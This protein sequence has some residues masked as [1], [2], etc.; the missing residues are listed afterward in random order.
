MKDYY[1]MYIPQ[2]VL[3]LLYSYGNLATLS[4]AVGSSAVA[5]VSYYYEFDIIVLNQFSLRLCQ[6]WKICD[7]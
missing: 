5:A 6:K 7:E 4:R 1:C 2:S 3:V